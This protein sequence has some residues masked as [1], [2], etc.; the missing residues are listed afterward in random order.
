M[1]DFT[2]HIRPVVKSTKNATPIHDKL[3]NC[4]LRVTRQRLIVAKYIFG[5]KKRLIDANRL[6]ED[7]A[8]SGEEISLATIYNTLHHFTKQDWSG[9]LHL[10]DKNHSLLPIA[11]IA[12]FSTTRAEKSLPF[13]VMNR[14][15]KSSLFPLKASK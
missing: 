3:E 7:I 12:V 14:M 1:L 9:R 8:S 6:Y 2:G 4:G 10:P 13:M 15:Y 5:R 11:V